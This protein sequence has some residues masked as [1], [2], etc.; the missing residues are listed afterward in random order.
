MALLR[1]YLPFILL[2]LLG[3]SLRIHELE[4]VP[5]RG[6]E[7]FSA[8]YWSDLPLSESLRRIAPL[9]PQPPLAFVLFRAWA[10]ILGGIDSV[11][12]LRFLSALGNTLGI[13]AMYGLAVVVGGSRRAGLLAAV[14]WAL[15]PYLVWHS[16]D[17]RNYAIWASASV[18]TL[19]LGLRL[20][21]CRGRHG[22]L[23]YF[24]AACFAALVFYGET[25]NVLAMSLLAVLLARDDRSFLRRFMLVQALVLAIAGFSF[26]V[27]Q[28]LSGF[29]G[30]YGGN[31]EAFALGDYFSR[32]IPSLMLGDVV[33]ARQPALTLALTMALALA[34]LLLWRGSRR[35]LTIIMTLIVLPFMLLGVAATL[36]DIFN[37]R[38][39]LG[40]APV[41]VLLMTL[42][43]MQASEVLEKLIRIKRTWLAMLLLS[44]WVLLSGYSLHAYFNDAGL[45]KA[46][47]WE[48]LGRFLSSRVEEKDL[49]IQLSVDP[50]FAYYY[51]GSAAETAL[52]AHA[53]QTAAEIEAL[54]DALRSEHESIYIAA[55]EQAGWPNAGAVE[56]WMGR[57][58]QEV[59]RT[60]FAGLPLRQY[61]EWR[62]AD[63]FAGAITR[64]GDVV[65]LLSHKIAATRLPSGELLLWVYWMPLSPSEAALKS[66]V[67]LYGAPN[68]ASGNHLFSQ[69]D[70]FPQDGRLDTRWW[71][72]GMVYRD[73]Y[74]LP[75]DKL[76]DGDY[77][78]S[79]GWYNPVDGERLLQR[80]GKSAY[81]LETISFGAGLRD[82]R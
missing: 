23:V 51:T 49:V 22:W 69:A 9:D 56:G 30:S 50:A 24:C 81:V 72:T 40:T 43:A 78:L 39:V 8:Q 58:M 61:M 79:V 54:L 42:G 20:I 29:I 3:F 14:I 12:S 46:P 10:I 26:V 11:F 31:L 4:A 73:V 53:G 17:F 63:P 6:D 66:F 77:Q 60:D 35:Q 18:T 48:E 41:F 28:V 52:P 16:Q 27:L 33:S 5:L 80:D 82:A 2:I 7:A 13:P 37:P 62:V 36:R 59:L 25:L 55:Q 34:A 45:R 44:P 71:R 74:Y 68:S 65:A 76:D 38:Y 64:F 75:V 57:N 15:H 67:H 47:A 21:R 70:K 19:W 1:H 32:F